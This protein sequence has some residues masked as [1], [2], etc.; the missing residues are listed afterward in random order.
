[1]PRGRKRMPRGPKK[2]AQPG[3]TVRSGRR[4]AWG[5]I[6]ADG[7]QRYPASLQIHFE[8]SVQADQHQLGHERVEN[9]LALEKP[10]KTP[11]PDHDD[12]LAIEV[13][14]FYPLGDATKRV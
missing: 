9:L 2:E 14:I 7:C 12:F 13:V 11:G 3:V 10:R 5:T 1:M 8:R 6:L 4:P